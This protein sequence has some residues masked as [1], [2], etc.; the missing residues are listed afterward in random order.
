MMVTWVKDGKPDV[1]MTGNGLL[2]GLVG[3]TAGC[4]GRQRAR[5]ADHRRASPERS[6][7]SPSPSSTRSRSTIR[8]VPSV[9]TAS[10]APSA[11]S[12]SGCSRRRRSMASSQQGS[13]LRRRSEPARQ[14]DHRRRR[15]RH[16]RPRHQRAPVLRPQEDGRPAGLGGGGARRPRHPRARR[17]GLRAGRP[18]HRLIP[19]TPADHSLASDARRGPASFGMRGSLRR[20]TERGPN[21]T[22][23]AHPE[24][25]PTRTDAATPTR[26]MR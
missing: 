14:P 24:L 12:L 13:V 8:S 21:T 5:R 17:S 19:R 26:A 3:I 23:T 2:A 16:L 22:M 20:D 9:S 25:R 11:R 4:C 18:R 15:R 1:A 7:S 10:A 6:S